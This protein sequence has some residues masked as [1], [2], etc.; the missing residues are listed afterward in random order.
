MAGFYAQTDK[1]KL[2]RVTGK[3]SATSKGR[4]VAL[5]S[6]SKTTAGMSVAGWSR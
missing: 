6:D 3:V 5:A 2:S 1:P 4:S